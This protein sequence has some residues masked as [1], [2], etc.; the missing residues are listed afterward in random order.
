MGGNALKNVVTR[1]Y[2]KDEYFS[3][4]DEVLSVFRA[5]FPE[6]R[7]DV[8]RA[9]RDKESFGDM[10]ILFET[11]EPSVNVLDFI[12]SA[13]S[14]KQYVKN[15]S[16]ISF[17]YKEFQIDVIQMPTVDYQTS[18]EYYS[19]NDLHNLIGRVVHKLGTKHG[20]QGLSMTLKDDRNYT[21][22]ELNISKDINRILAYAG[23]DSDR[24]Q[25]G[26]DNLVDLFTYVTS[27]EFFNKSIYAYENRNHT[28][29]VRDKKRKTYSE[30]LDWIEPQNL[31]AYP[32]E[33]LAEKG[34]RFLDDFRLNR[35]FE[36][37]PEFKETYNAAIVSYN[38]WFESKS[39]FNGNIVSEITGL[40]QLDLSNFMKH[41]K[42]LKSLEE[43]SGREWLISIGSNAVKLWIYEEWQKY[44]G[45]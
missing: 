26:F 42:S 8:L 27:S 6:R 39:L 17:E 22:A 29:R 12:K 11:K 32:Y 23:Y 1:R 21:Y 31:N 30:F 28:A 14:P 5:A 19:W 33:N 43:N 38:I 40:T 45:N 10:D 34:G 7:I 4:A 16:V 36:F 20:H 9:Y 3:L 18:Y 24:Y 13:F 41:L 35:I 15:S 37:F 2:Q 25:Q 44:K